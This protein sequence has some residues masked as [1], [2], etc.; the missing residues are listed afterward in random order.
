MPAEARLCPRCELV[1][2]F[3]I[4]HAVDNEAPATDLT[5]FC[6]KR[7]S[8]ERHEGL[9]EVMCPRCGESMFFVQHSDISFGDV[10]V[11]AESWICECGTTLETAMGPDGA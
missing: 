4:E 9:V 10:G 5:A 6:T 8:V 3:V 2:I 11:L 1:S 7:L